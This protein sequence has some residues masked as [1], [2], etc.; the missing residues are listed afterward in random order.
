MT[1]GSLDALETSE[2]GTGEA[3]AGLKSSDPGAERVTCAAASGRIGEE[4]T[5][6]GE[7]EEHPSR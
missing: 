5:K 7:H 3:P 6:A 4:R 1:S 2:L